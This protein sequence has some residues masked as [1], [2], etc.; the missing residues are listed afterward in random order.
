[1]GLIGCSRAYFQP[2]PSDAEYYKKPGY[3]VAQTRAELEKCGQNRKLLAHPTPL[4]IIANE[5]TRVR[6]CMEDKGFVGEDGFTAA[7]AC[8]RYYQET[9]KI[10]LP[11]CIARGVFK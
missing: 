3:D 6:F 8:W 2:P 1:M 5:S 9:L 10:K 7:K 11:V 4:A